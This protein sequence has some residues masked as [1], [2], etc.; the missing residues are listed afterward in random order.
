ML[1]HGRHQPAMLCSETADHAA[2]Q[3]MSNQGSIAQHCRDATLQ[4]DLGP[5][6]PAGGL[7]AISAR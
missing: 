7:T 1:T 2:L 3:G 6:Q 5:G 4:N